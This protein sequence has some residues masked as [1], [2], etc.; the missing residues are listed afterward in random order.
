M[1]RLWMAIKLQLR[2]HFQNGITDGNLPNW[3]PFDNTTDVWLPSIIDTLY[4]A[5]K[6]AYRNVIFP[7]KICL[8]FQFF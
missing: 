2:Y 5:L 4:K 6:L 3:L 8:L 7:K 1:G